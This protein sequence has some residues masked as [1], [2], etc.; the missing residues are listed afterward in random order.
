MHIADGILNTP[1]TLAADA[2]CLGALYLLGRKAD[3]SQVP[4]MGLM[5]AALFV[6]SLIH[7][8]L[9][10]TSVHLGLYGL[11]GVLLGPGAFPMVFLALLF[12]ALIFQH[13][14]LLSIGLNTLNMGTGALSA[15][16]L[17]KV[18]PAP[19]VFRA[20]AAGFI[21]IAV[22]AVLMAVE[23][24][25]SGYGRGIYVLLSV[26]LIPAVIEGLLT[27]SVVAFFLRVRS[28]IIEGGKR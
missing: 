8:P 16:L 7:F 5:A 25:L 27:S 11:A 21:G 12:Q 2:V 26:Y 1:V 15:W 9:A 24:E 14:G 17:W 13:G 23:F 10:G 3:T 19:A 20:F 22:P 4:K 28:P 18:L 6:S